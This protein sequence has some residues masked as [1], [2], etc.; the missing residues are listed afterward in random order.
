MVDVIH[1]NDVIVRS[2]SLTELLLALEARI[3]VEPY[4]AAKCAERASLSDEATLVALH[5]EYL[6]GRKNGDRHKLVEID[7]K[8]HVLIGMAAG[9]Y[10]LLELLSPFQERRS[11]LWFLPH[12]QVNDFGETASNHDKLIRGIREHQPEAASATMKT[13]LKSLAHRIVSSQGVGT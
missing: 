12:W 11:R 10:L 3:L 8:M 7:R 13:H 2:D 5:R 1:R 4:C 9:N 6:E